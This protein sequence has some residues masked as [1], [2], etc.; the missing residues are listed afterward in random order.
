LILV[1]HLRLDLAL[2][3]HREQR[4][5]D[6][7]AVVADD[8]GGGPDRIDDLEVRV[9]NHAQ[10]GLG[11]RGTAE[12]ERG[13]GGDDGDEAANCHGVL[14]VRGRYHSEGVRSPA[15]ARR[16]PWN[17]TCGAGTPSSWPPP[18]ARAASRVTRP[19]APCSSGWPPSIP[20]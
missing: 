19:R 3:I 12:G 18:S 5:V 1:H 13:E 10:R 9:Q 4:V 16:F 7:V 11:R 8:G 15:H 6:H 17:A 14:R 2:G 20:R